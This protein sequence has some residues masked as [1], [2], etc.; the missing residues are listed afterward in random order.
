MCRP[1]NLI[2]IRFWDAKD[3][4][5]CVDIPSHSLHLYIVL[6]QHFAPGKIPLKGHL[7]INIL[8][9][10]DAAWA[11]RTRR[12]AKSGRKPVRDLHYIYN[13]SFFVIQLFPSAYVCFILR[14][15]GQIFSIPP[16]LE[17][18]GNA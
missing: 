8:H 14:N 12:S 17:V 6:F 11:Y 15:G 9:T 18:S 5:V 3:F 10:Q 16:N 4:G 7:P 1:I 13:V 2:A